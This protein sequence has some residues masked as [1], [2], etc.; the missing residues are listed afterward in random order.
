[1]DCDLIN[2]CLRGTKMR[3]VLFIALFFFLSFS[4]ESTEND[5][6]AYA[7]KSGQCNRIENVLTCESKDISMAVQ[8]KSTQH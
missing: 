2:G 1:M 3:N 7:I 4:I 5:P 6:I 8:F